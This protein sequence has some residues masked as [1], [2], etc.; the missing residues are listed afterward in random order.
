MLNPTSPLAR[1]LD[2]PM[3]PGVVRWIGLRPAR[4]APMLA[5]PSVR[6]DP[7]LGLDGD[8]YRSATARK[9]Q[10]TLIGTQDLLAIADALG[11]ELVTP[12]QHQPTCAARAAVPDWDRLAGGDRRLPSLL[13]HGRDTGNG[14][15]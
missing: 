4:R 6:L 1:L 15:L 13:P 3:R 11:L 12:D 10:V 7:E 14:R 2:A 5:L 8:H 9:R